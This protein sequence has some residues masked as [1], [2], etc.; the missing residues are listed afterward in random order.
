MFLNKIKEFL[1]NE[2]GAETLEYVA[3]AAVIIAAGAAAYNSAA[4]STVITAGMDD[5]IATIGS[6]AGTP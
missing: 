6:P 5:I 1:K 4:V 2:K 3:I